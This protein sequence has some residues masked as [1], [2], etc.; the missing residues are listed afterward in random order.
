MPFM[1]IGDDAHDPPDYDQTNSRFARILGLE[2][3]LCLVALSA[4]MT[5]NFDDSEP[6][7]EQASLARTAASKHT[8]NRLLLVKNWHL[9]TCCLRVQ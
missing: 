4:S 2:F 8:R 1:T 3:L 7:E 5:N 9:L 6:A